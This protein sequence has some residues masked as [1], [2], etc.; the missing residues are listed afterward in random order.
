LPEVPRHT[1]AQGSIT[2]DDWFTYITARLIT[3][4]KQLAC[5]IFKILGDHEPI[6]SIL[7]WIFYAARIGETITTRLGTGH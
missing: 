6:T 1:E 5:N 7:T 4:D 2:L 3:R